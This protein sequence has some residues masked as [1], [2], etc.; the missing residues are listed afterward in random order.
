MLQQSRVKNIDL[1]IIRLLASDCRTSYSNIASAVGITPSAVKERIN[2]IISKGVIRSFVVVINP[3]IFGYEKE[4]FLILKNIDKTI[5][6][7][8]IF[9][10][11]SLLGD[12]IAY[13]MQLERAAMFVLSVR[14][15]AEEKI[16]I[17]TDL[18]K[19]VAVE[20]IFGSYKP[21]TMRIHSSL[22]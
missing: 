14:A 2:K 9:K 12:I 16:G 1:H 19:P 13:A 6:E 22:I 7:Q 20:G 10:K 3:V 21:V 8:A 17:L 15:G 11:L 18:L 4:C 5:K